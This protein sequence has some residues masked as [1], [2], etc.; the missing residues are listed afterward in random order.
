MRVSDERLNVLASPRAWGEEPTPNE[1]M[2]MA[3][4]LKVMRKL[5][6]EIKRYL[7][8]DL[9]GTHSKRAIWLKELLQSLDTLEES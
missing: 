9:V 1:R 2:N 4:E 6:G 8:G 7:K 5:V 3:H